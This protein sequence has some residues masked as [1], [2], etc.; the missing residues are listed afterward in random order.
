MNEHKFKLNEDMND[1]KLWSI[2]EAVEQPTKWKVDLRHNIIE[3]Y[4]HPVLDAEGRVMDIVYK[5]FKYNL[6]TDITNYE[7]AERYL[8]LKE[9]IK[10]GNVDKYYSGKVQPKRRQNKVTEDMVKTIIELYLKGVTRLDISYKL[11]VSKTTVN[12]YIVKELGNQ[13]TDT[14]APAT[15]V[16]EDWKEL[17]SQGLSFADIAS[18]Y[19]V[20]AS[21]VHYHTNKVRQTKVAGRPRKYTPEIVVKWVEMKSTGA[22]YREIAEKH[23]VAPTTVKYHIT[24]VKEVS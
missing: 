10:Q 16:L 18:K 24:K 2:M 13:K 6:R 19:N 17:R 22:T 9:D 12:N 15:Q 21:T 23:Q 11:G 8:Q 5:S 3:V 14:V 1:N 20:T 7:V 4:P